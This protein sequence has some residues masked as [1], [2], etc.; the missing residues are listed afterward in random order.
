M[1]VPFMAVAWRE[2]GDRGAEARENANQTDTPSRSYRPG[3]VRRGGTIKPMQHKLTIARSR[4][5]W[6]SSLAL[7][8]RS[9][10]EDRIR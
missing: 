3:C 8:R 10:Q 7:M 5:S 9:V 6:E 2:H 4:L 1:A